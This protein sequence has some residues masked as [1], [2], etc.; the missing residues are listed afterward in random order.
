MTDLAAGDVSYSIDVKRIGP[1]SRRYNKVTLTF[2]DAALTMPAGGLPLTNAKMGCPNSLE[3]VNVIGHSIKVSSTLSKVLLQYD[4]VNNKIQCYIDPG[5]AAHTH[6]L[7]LNNADVAD[8]ATTRINAGTNLLGANTGSDIAIAGVVD[9]SGAGGIVQ[10]A[11]VAKA[12]MAEFTSAPDA[13]STIVLE[14]VG[15]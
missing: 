13:S 4:P 1:R 2:G 12:V 6:A 9:T 14:V 7:H 10:A 3:S 15:W 11:A 5:I 8:G